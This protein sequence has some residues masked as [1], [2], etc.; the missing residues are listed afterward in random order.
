MKKINNKGFTLVELLVVITI[1][2]II[3]VVA[4]QNF[5]G[6]T[7]KAISGRKINDIGTIE[8]ALQQFKADNNYY[9]M[10]QA[11]DATT[12]L[13]GYNSWSVTN[14]SNVIDVDY[15]GKEINTIT[16]WSWGWIVY[17]TGA[18][19][20]SQVWAKW[21]IGYTTD[22]TKK[23]LSKELYD[24]EIWDIKLKS[25]GK[26]MIDSGIG[27]YVYW[28]YAQPK[29]KWNWNKTGIS[30]IYYNIATSVK[31]KDSESYES[32][33][34]W[35]FDENSCEI[36]SGCPKSLIGTAS[37]HTVTANNISLLNKSPQEINISSTGA[38]Q[39]IPYPVKDFQ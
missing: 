10:P 26:K 39:W 20:G 18:Y 16:S 13:W 38:N 36:P 35:D 11:Y 24:P 21:V 28:I 6:A 31:K 14:S 2:A 33:I 9:P 12:N 15:D 19:S 32:Y 27:K 37:G 23:Y 34:V 5:G 30:G 8:T 25:N 22:F 29:A 3:S 7:D 1:L 17:G 4:Y